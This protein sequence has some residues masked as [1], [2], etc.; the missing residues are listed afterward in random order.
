MMRT[1]KR[2]R[3][4][5]AAERAEFRGAYERLCDWHLYLQNRIGPMIKDIGGDAELAA[6]LDATS[7]LRR[8][9]SEYQAGFA[10]MEE[11]ERKRQRKQEERRERD[12]LRK[13][14]KR[15]YQKLQMEL[16]ALRA[17]AAVPVSVPAGLRI[18]DVV[19]VKR[20][21]RWQAIKA[22]ESIRSEWRREGSR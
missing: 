7:H 13:Q 14:Q 17:A 10:V 1:A 11:A 3:S 15:Q 6:A 9:M 4:M 2:D 19:V 18:G 22:G 20:P 16:A 12:R 8:V 21:E 5:N